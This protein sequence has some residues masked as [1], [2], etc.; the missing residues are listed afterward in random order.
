MSSCRAT[1]AKRLIGMTKRET[2]I[3]QAAIEELAAIELELERLAA[4]PAELHES[5][6]TVAQWMTRARF[7]QAGVHALHLRAKELDRQLRRVSGGAR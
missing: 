3:F 6:E 5:G 1:N 7:R 4:N 2:E